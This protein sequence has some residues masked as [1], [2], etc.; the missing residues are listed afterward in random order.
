MT[1]VSSESG[2][3][4]IEGE[5]QEAIFRAIR[6]IPHGRVASYGEVAA[7]AGLPGRARLVGR[8]LRESP[9]SARLPWHRVLRAGGYSA[10]PRGSDAEAEQLRRL[11]TE[12]VETLNGKVP[13]RFFAW[14]D[15]DLDE[16]LWRLE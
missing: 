3:S 14:R 13:G 7:R 8:M 6:A 2:T 1:F 12:G 4:M 11:Q 15:A 9:A 10:F 5:P 16:A